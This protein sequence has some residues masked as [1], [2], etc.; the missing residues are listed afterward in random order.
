MAA[1]GKRLRW[2]NVQL[3]LAALLQTMVL[4]A[5]LSFAGNWTTRQTGFLH[6]LWISLENFDR[7][8]GK[9]TL[10]IIPAYLRPELIF[11]S[12]WMAGLAAF[13]WWTLFKN[14]QLSRKIDLL[15]TSFGGFAA[16]IIIA[17]FVSRTTYWH[18]EG[19]ADQIETILQREFFLL[20]FPLIFAFL[21]RA[22]MRRQVAK[23][24][25]K[26]A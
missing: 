3:F 26:D 2:Y 20:L 12:L 15:G 23:D 14:T 10:D 25:M 4:F 18:I 5:P 24:D 6:P 7:S 1:G 22:R 21:A 9:S 17:F 11:L 19:E 8:S 13:L 16:M